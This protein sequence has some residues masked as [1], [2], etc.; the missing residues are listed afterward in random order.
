MESDEE[1][2]GGGGEEGEKDG[3]PSRAEPRDHEASQDPGSR[4]GPDGEADAEEQGRGEGEGSPACG[5]EG[6]DSRGRNEE[7]SDEEARR[8]PS[9][10]GGRPN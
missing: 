4:G 3:S 7:N 8:A 6:S 9:E 10:G 1:Q 2:V 5:S